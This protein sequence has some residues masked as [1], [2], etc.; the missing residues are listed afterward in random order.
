MSSKQEEQQD[1]TAEDRLLNIVVDAIDDMKGVD[2]LVIDVR[3]MTSIT[4]RMVIT[5]GTSTRHVK[6]IADSVALKAKQ[7]G[8]PALGVEGAQAAE[9]V[10][11]DLG[12]VV[13]HVMTPAIREFYALE[14]LWA[15][16]GDKSEND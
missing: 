13:V 11:I 6:S 14:K 2:L 1:N 16:V 9:W 10:L 8:F 3:D 4:D 15:V 5:S 12:D 7:G